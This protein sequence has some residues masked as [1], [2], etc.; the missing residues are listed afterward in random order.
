MGWLYEVLATLCA[1]FAPLLKMYGIPNMHFPDAI[2]MFVVIPF[3]HLL[4]DQTI[5]GII[6]E[7]SWYQGLRYMLGIYVEPTTRRVNSRDNAVP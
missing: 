4:N 6:S 3:A 5:K 7:E 1:A 2:L